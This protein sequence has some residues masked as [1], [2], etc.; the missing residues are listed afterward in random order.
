MMNLKKVLMV[1]SLGVVLTFAGC[2]VQKTQQGENQTQN[3]TTQEASAD[4]QKT[5][6]IQEGTKNM[7]DV[8]KEMKTELNNKEEDK[9][10]KTAEDLEGNWKNF[11]DNVKAKAPG[12]YGKIEESLD[13]INAAIKVKP[14]DT[15]VLNINIDSLDNELEQLQK[16]Q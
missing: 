10:A 15:K 5:L 11:E 1:I 9:A 12:I 13:T 3:K 4:K 6:T 14:L 2:G 7:R 16:L 8:I